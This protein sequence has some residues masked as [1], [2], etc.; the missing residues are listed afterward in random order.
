MGSYSVERPKPWIET[1]CLYSGP[2]SRAAGCNIYLKLDNLQPSGSFKSR[3]IGYMMQRAAEASSTGSSKNDIHFYCSSGGNAGLACA[4]SAAT[5][6]CRATIVVPTLAPA[7][8]VEKL[9]AL[10]ATVVQ[11][12]SN[13]S[14][15]D[16]TWTV[17]TASVWLGISSAKN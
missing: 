7:H 1:P 12:G 8:M 9:R 17:E 13:F 14:E 16:A 11:T 6:G 4:T 15:A 10:G 2:L 3:G 5:L